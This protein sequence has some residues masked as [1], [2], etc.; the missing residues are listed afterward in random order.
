M[1]E[2]HTVTDRDESHSAG[3][4]ANDVHLGDPEAPWPP[5]VKVCFL[6][7][8]ISQSGPFGDAIENCAHVVFQKQMSMPCPDVLPDCHGL[9][10]SLLVVKGVSPLWQKKKRKHSQPNHTQSRS[11]EDEA[12]HLSSQQNTTPET[13]NPEM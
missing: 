1:Q 4:Q 2:L 3:P 9:P 11:Q 13:G 7:A 5:V 10:L 12:T 6:Y 8:S